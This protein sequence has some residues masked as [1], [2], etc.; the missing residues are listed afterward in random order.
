MTDQTNAPNAELVAEVRDTLGRMKITGYGA[1]YGDLLKRCAA[2]LSRQP[3]GEPVGEGM[4]LVPRGIV[5]PKNKLVGRMGEMAPRGDMNLAVN[6][7]DD[8]DV[9]IECW[10]VR[11]GRSQQAAVEFCTVGPGGGRSPRTREA[12]IALMVAIEADNA[13]TP[14]RAWPVLLAAAAKEGKS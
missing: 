4:V 14:D 12:L 1:M 10:E 7:Q 6:L 8:G 3:A 11:Y 13:E 9:I 5:W 2:A